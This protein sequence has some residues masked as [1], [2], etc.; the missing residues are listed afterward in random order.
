MVKS[1]TPTV[2]SVKTLYSIIAA[3]KHGSD[4][5]MLKIDQKLADFA[6]VHNRKPFISGAGVNL[7]NATP[8]AGSFIVRF[9]L[10]ITIR[11]GHEDG[12]QHQVRISILDPSVNS[13]TVMEN[14]GP[15]VAPQDVGKLVGTL[16]LGSLPSERIDQESVLPVAFGFGPLRVPQPGLYQLIT[17]I[18]SVTSSIKFDVIAPPVPKPMRVNG[19]ITAIDNSTGVKFTGPGGFDLPDLRIR[20]IGNDTGTEVDN[21]EIQD[22]GTVI[23]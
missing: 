21:A 12:G 10:A 23:E 19:S 1:M 15:E 7:I 22:Y 5:R 4:E 16:S 18:G 13:V 20:S 3:H 17:E 6:Q 11:A 14:Q 8:D 2:I 9:Y